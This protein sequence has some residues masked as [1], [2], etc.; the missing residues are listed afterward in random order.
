MEQANGA[1]DPGSVTT[2]ALLELASTLFSTW[3]APIER[4]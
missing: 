4:K 1:A 2:G 3:V